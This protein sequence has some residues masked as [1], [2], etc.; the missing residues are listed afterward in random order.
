MRT[1]Y[2]IALASLVFAAAPARAQQ[3]PPLPQGPAGTVTLSIADYDRLVD[4]AA[5][6]IKREDPPPVPAVV[7]R[8]D[9]RARV[10]GD[11]VRGTLRLDG[12]VFHRGHVK[13]PLL[14]GG[15]L[16]EATAQGTVV[17]LVQEGD[18]HL[19]ILRGPAAFALTLEWAAPVSAAPGRASIALPSPLAGSVTAT[20]DLP[21]DPAEVR[22]EPG[23]VI[24]RQTAGGRTIVEVTLEPGRRSQVSWSVRES[25]A[26]AAQAEARTLADVRSLITIGEADVRMTSVVDVAVVSGEPRVFEVRLPAG[27][28]VAGVTGASI[29]TTD[30]RPGVVAVTLKDPAQRRHQFVITLERAH[31][32]GSFKVDT[33]FPTVPAAQREVGE[34]AI[35]GTGT[36]EVNASGDEAMRRMDVRESHA[37]L[38]ALARQ[39][40]LAAFRYQR[41]ANETRTLTMDV[42]RFADAPVIAAAAERAVATTLVTVEGRT[43]TEITL[44]LR[45]RAQPFMKVVLPSGSTMLSVEVAGE[46]AKPVL[47]ADGTRVPLLRAGLRP[48]GPYTVSFVYLHA[49]QPFAKR[50]DAEMVLPQMDVPITVLEWELFLPDR[51]S[52]K[53]SG[54]NV[55]PARLAAYTKEGDLAYSG[56]VAG[57]PGGVADIPMPPAAPGQITGRVIDQVGAPL[58]GARI[59]VRAVGG[60]TLTAVSDETGLYSVHGVPPGPVTVTT[61]LAGFRS[62]RVEFTMDGHQGRNAHFRLIVGA[63]TETV[64]VQGQASEAAARPNVRV[65]EDALQAAPSQNVLNLQRRV[66]GVLPVRIDVPRTGTAHRFVKPLVLDE[67]ANVTFRYKTR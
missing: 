17:P 46:T 30:T 5:L 10:A 24:Q 49:G 38:R 52:A 14:N 4:R 66:S 59:T 12:E 3:R 65:A 23:L 53:A 44:T 60:R 39:P 20:L 48:T 61:E 63:V 13:V 41:R 33:G 37:S 47:G 34:V 40:L 11:T 58:P 16:L 45:N 9:V 29:D 43:L 28:E 35:E 8:A 19:A 32:P 50:G 31:G 57:L 62:T 27:Y 25:A 56:I 54:G 6:P 26:P 22:V 7:G 15:T 21:G 51:Y 2:S 42:T 55:L 36:I 18:Q 67:P 1:I 64:A